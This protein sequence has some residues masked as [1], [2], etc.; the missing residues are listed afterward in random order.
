MQPAVAEFLSG[1]SDSVDTL[2]LPIELA[3]DPMA[4]S[5]VADVA[6]LLGLIAIFWGL[7]RFLMSAGMPKLRPFVF[8]S[9][10]TGIL[11]LFF[12]NSAFWMVK[13]LKVDN[14]GVTLTQ[15]LGEDPQLTWSEITGLRFDNGRLFPA[16]SDDASLILVAGDRELAIPRFIP[17]SG[18]AVRRIDALLQEKRT[19]PAGSP[20]P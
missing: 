2:R 15:H 5:R 7:G 1:L 10:L 11:L 3:V 14:T 18:A 20:S 19:S 12:T 13:G 16:F 4:G 8:A 6:L 9:G 17:G